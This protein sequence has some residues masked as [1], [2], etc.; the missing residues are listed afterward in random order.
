QAQK[1]TNEFLR[2]FTYSLAV[3]PHWIGKSDLFWY[4]YRTHQGKQWYRVNARAKTKEPLFD[5]AKLA[6]L[7]SEQVRK[8]LDPLQLPLTRAS[9]DDDG[10]KF[11]F[12]AEDY[13]F[14][15]DLNTEKINKFG[16]A[17]RVQTGPANMSPEQQQR[18]RE[19]LGE[20]RFREFMEKQKD[21][22]KDE[23]KDGESTEDESFS[24]A[25]LQLIERILREE[26]IGTPSPLTPLPLPE[27]ERG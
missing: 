7:L 16:K 9:V 18:M 25:E 8:P 21:E 2:Q 1:F 26:G 23:K 14:E 24:D 19:I 20:E 17:P 5:R 11:K 22:K 6:G 4:E 27:G 15:Y 3:E 10:V 12:V 13:Q